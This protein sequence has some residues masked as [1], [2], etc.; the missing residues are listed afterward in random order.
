MGRWHIWNSITDESPNY[1][2]K[3]VNNNTCQANGGSAFTHSQ[4]S[5]ERA[6][7]GVRDARNPKFEKKLTLARERFRF[8]CVVKDLDPFPMA[9]MEHGKPERKRRKKRGETSDG[10]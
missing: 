2:S 10:G 7:K 6:G 9:Q 5:E 8:E 1:C 4:R 3:S